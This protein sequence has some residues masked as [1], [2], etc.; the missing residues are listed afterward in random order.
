M[1]L[2]SADATCENRTTKK[3]DSG[4]TVIPRWLQVISCFDY[5]SVRVPAQIR[6]S[7]AHRKTGR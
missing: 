3:N 1:N 5:T 6:G 2:R 7:D 4:K